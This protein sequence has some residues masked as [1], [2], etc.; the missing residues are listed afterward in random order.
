MSE[1]GEHA[2]AEFV[3]FDPGV[4]ILDIGLPLIDG[5]E[6]ARRMRRMLA[7]EPRLLIALTGYGQHA[8]R[9]QAI[10]AGF[11]FHFVKPAEMTQLLACIR[12]WRAETRDL[13][14]R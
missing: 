8:D 14:A 2:L 12:G 13:D 9:T 6:V 11:D 7:G 10:D 3:R 1:D 5:S 4:V